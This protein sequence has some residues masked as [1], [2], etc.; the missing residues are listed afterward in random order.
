MQWKKGQMK[1]S[2]WHEKNSSQREDIKDRVH[3]EREKGEI[4][5]ENK[6]FLELEQI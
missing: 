3:K 2:D 4:E 1:M 5:I 6:N